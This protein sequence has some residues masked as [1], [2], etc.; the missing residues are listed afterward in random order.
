M[1]NREFK[2][3][4][5]ALTDAGEKMRARFRRYCQKWGFKQADLVGLTHEW[6]AVTMNQDRRDELAQQDYETFETQ[7]W[8]RLR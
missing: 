2:A 4:V 6:D 3:K 8:E 7:E 5:H 1:T